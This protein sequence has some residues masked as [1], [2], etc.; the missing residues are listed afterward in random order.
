MK[1][2][3]F[4]EYKRVRWDELKERF[5]LVRALQFPYAEITKCHNCGV[6]RV[7][8]LPSETWTGCSYCYACETINFIIYG[9]K[10]GGGFDAVY[11]YQEKREKREHGEKEI[12]SHNSIQPAG[13]HPS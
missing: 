6:N 2:F 12:I 13:L 1:T 11:L 4:I 8:S 9:D 7:I 3:E 10:M 5:D